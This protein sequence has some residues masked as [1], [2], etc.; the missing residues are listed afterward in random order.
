MSE[1]PSISIIRKDSLESSSGAWRLGMSVS[2]KV[3]TVAS[4]QHRLTHG[5][6]TA[7]NPWR[8]QL[9]AAEDPVPTAMSQSIDRHSL[10][11]RR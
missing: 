1:F 9:L 5:G 10:C 7:W 4:L 8:A 11:V 3:N 6:Q 2:R